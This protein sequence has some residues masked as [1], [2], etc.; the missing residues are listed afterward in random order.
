MIRPKHIIIFGLL[1]LLFVAGGLASYEWLGSLTYDVSR[2][3]PRIA[4][5]IG[6]A[7]PG[8]KVELPELTARR[9]PIQKQI[10]VTA[11]NVRF[12]HALLA[13]PAMLDKLVIKLDQAA[14]FD[15][16]VRVESVSG[17][18][19]HAAIKSSLKALLKSNGS[20]I[21]VAVPWNNALTSVS[22]TD[23]AV[24]FFDT[25]SQ[26]NLHVLSPGL[27]V[28]RQL[29]HKELL[30][31]KMRATVTGAG[32]KLELV[33]EGKAVP[34][35]KW[36]EH[37]T[38]SANKLTGLLKTLY[39][40][41]GI[42]DI[43]GPIT[44]DAKLVS[45]DALNATIYLQTGAG[46]LTWPKFYKKPL[47]LTKLALSATW[48][49]NSSQLKLNSFDAQLGGVEVKA[50]GRLDTSLPADSSIKAS[51]DKAT[52]AQLLG[53]WPIGA[54]PGGKAWI[55]Q[56]IH[57]GG[58]RNGAFALENKAMVLDFIFDKLRVDYRSPMPMLENAAG[59]GRLTNSGLSLV[60]ED[61]TIASLKVT[62][63]TI[64]LQGFDRGPGD[65]LLTMPLSG[66]VPAVLTLLDHQPF[67]FISRYGLKPDS[68]SGA[69]SGTL[70]MRFPL[71][72]D[73]KMDQIVFNAD[74]ETKNA[75]IPD[76]FDNK[77]LSNA[78]L[79]FLITDHN[80]DAKGTGILGAQAVTLRWQ[81]DFTGK[82]ATPTQYD[83]NAHTSVTALAALGIDISGLA[84]GSLVSNV[85]LNGH[86]G[87]IIDGN[88]SAD[89]SHTQ[90]ELPVFGI[91]KPTGFHATITG[92][93]RQ[94][95]RTLLLSDLNLDSSSVQAKLSGQ[96]PLDAGRNHFDITSFHLGETQLNGSVDYAEGSVLTLNIKGGQLDLRE[97]LQNWRH[98][99][100]TTKSEAVSELST[101]VLARLDKIR[102]NDNADLTLTFA[103]MEFRGDTLIALNAKAKQSG[104][105]VT[106]RLTTL[107]GQRTFTL[108]APD[109]GSIG[110][111][112]NLFSG[113][114]GGALTVN[115]I[116]QGQG[117]GL[118]ISGTAQMKDFR[119]TN[120]PALAKTLTIASLTGLR[121]M[122]MGRGIL[123]DTV[124]L[125][126]QLRRGV[127]DIHGARATGA[128]LGITLEGQVLQS[129]GKTD[130]RGVIIPSYT[131]NSALGK[132]P[133]LG[134]V[135]TGGKGQGVIGFNY[136][137]SGPAADPKITVAASSGLALGPLRQLF[138]GHKPALQEAG[139]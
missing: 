7:A 116:L 53:L 134:K 61:G 45:T 119:V 19:F 13:R 68:L 129:L 95:G 122:V 62:P 74:A 60:I 128:S 81:E 42:P 55:S 112:L 66:S 2:F 65:L 14:L 46:V 18:G 132:I 25:D 124:L 44:I 136:R 80:L 52:V 8:L 56:N 94:Q 69:I 10:I 107:K 29:L 36:D 32:S 130:L 67:Q 54:A 139:P 30:Q 79:R 41:S 85:H 121:D 92:G 114:K 70:H 120:T 106:T 48:Q 43:S 24:D 105:D 16:I 103:D 6:T 86:K 40:Q 108:Q 110:R 126:F 23:I 38:V 125:P 76:I 47:E 33:S 22:L 57:A 111:G 64:V 50:S 49:A 3:G 138:R 91:V 73:L 75:S 100:A 15:G 37:I 26:T 87:T 90:M 1:T 123:F 39:R 131:V 83:V 99:A 118:T 98:A 51:F 77:P 133:V 4:E 89:V 71:I 127:F 28:Q 21:T 113:G 35:G 82:S 27:I 109:A 34:F 20:G 117:P 104:A 84:S 5:V 115:A 135:L 93:L 102:L 12:N 78:N 96:V 59:R 31:I 17:E 58:I 9:D 72:R 101:H 137:I 88:F 11:L 97:S 63:A